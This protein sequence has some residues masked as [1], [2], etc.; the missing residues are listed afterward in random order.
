M[1]LRGE[2][3]FDIFVYAQDSVVY[4]SVH[5]VVVTRAV[6]FVVDDDTR[7]IAPVMLEVF[8]LL[9]ELRRVSIVEGLLK[10]TA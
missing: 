5:V 4:D 10:H 9:L 1:V 8:T 3:S 6:F 7:L 2:N